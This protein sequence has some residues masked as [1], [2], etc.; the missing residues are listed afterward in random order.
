[1]SVPIEPSASWPVDGHRRHQHLQVF[2]RV[3]ER[4][5]ADQQRLVIRLMHVA[6]ASGSASSSI[7]FSS[8]H[9]F[10]GPLVDQLAL[11]LVVVDDP[12]LLHVDQENLARLKPPFLDDV[13]GLDRQHADFGWP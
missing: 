10:H 8:S 5:L 6:S 7:R 13:F 2:V 3:A 12:A 1:M 9:R 4:M 11:D